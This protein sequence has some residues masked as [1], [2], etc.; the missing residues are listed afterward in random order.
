M[1]AS[2]GVEEVVPLLERPSSAL[3]FVA[4]MTNATADEC[5]KVQYQI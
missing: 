2:V 5:C 4:V 3:L 1:G